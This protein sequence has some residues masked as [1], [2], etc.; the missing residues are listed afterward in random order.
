MNIDSILTIEVFREQKIGW[1]PEKSKIYFILPAWP[2]YSWDRP[3]QR[4]QPK[5]LI[6]DWENMFNYPWF[7]SFNNTTS[8]VWLLEYQVVSQ[9]I[10]ID[11]TSNVSRYH[12]KEVC[13]NEKVLDGRMTADRKIWTF[14]LRRI[15]SC[16][17]TDIGWTCPLTQKSKTCH[18]PRNSCHI[19][20][21]LRCPKLTQAR[22]Q[23][24]NLFI[25]RFLLTL[26][27][28]SWDME[29]A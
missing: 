4:K 10:S 14:P 23:E 1:P 21:K 11:D 28:P 2:Y 7:T 29:G 3:V 26:F 25:P 27:K 15:L 20:S 9:M 19:M 17:D 18:G 24:I 22:T 16:H 6:E 13:K 12:S 5:C 8:I